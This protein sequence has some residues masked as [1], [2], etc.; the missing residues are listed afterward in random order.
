MHPSRTPSRAHMFRPAP[1]LW[2]AI[3]AGAQATPSQEPA[4]EPLLQRCVRI[5]A[6]GAPID[7]SVGHAAPYVIDFDGDGVRDLLVGEFGEGRFPDECLP[8]DVV[9]RFGPG[10]FASSKL[11]VYRNI[12]T[13]SAPRFGGFQYMEAGGQ[14]ASIPST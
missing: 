3:T 13:N 1:V 10:A 6:D 2:I 12:G 7:V 14:V 4:V 11:R 9:E 8:A 5:E